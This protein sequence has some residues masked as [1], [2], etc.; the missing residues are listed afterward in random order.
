LPLMFVT[1][2]SVPLKNSARRAFATRVINLRRAT[3]RASTYAGLTKLPTVATVYQEAR[4]TALAVVLVLA[5]AT[6]LRAI[7][8]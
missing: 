1:P 7:P 6:M 5:A 8:I 4:M 2:E 3:R